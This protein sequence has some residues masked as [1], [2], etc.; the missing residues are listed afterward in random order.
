MSNL[1][2]LLE[3]G[4]Q[5]VG[6]DLILRHKVVGNFRNG[7]FYCTEEGLLEL[8]TVEVV[9]KEVKAP[10]AKKAAASETPEAPEGDVTIDV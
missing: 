10:K 4:A 9:A 7:D 5:V 3:R 1:D 6:G 2:K 8:D